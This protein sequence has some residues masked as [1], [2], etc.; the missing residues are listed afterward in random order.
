MAQVCVKNLARTTEKGPS[1]KNGRAN[2]IIAS[3][4]YPQPSAST[5]IIAMT[6]PLLMAAAS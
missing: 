2:W 3:H 1:T 5:V 4:Q 6:R